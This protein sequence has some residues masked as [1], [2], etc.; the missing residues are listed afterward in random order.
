MPNPPSLPESR[1]VRAVLVV[2]TLSKLAGLEFDRDR[3]RSMLEIVGGDGRAD[4]T[5]LEGQD[6]NARGVLNYLRGLGDA[7]SDTVLVY[8]SGHGATDPGRG[9]ALTFTEGPP[10]LRSTLRAELARLRPR[11][12]VLISDCCSNVVKLPPA[13]GAPGAPDPTKT[14]RSLF[15]RTY[16]VVDINASTFD[17]R[18]GLEESAWGLADGGIFTKA[19]DETV[20]M[21]PFDELDRNRD[22][23]VTWGEC[24]PLVRNK[25]AGFYAD[26]RQQVLADPGRYPPR[27]VESLKRQSS[28]TPQAFSLDSGQGSGGG[29]GGRRELGILFTPVT[30]FDAT[31]GANVIG[32]R[33]DT[34]RAGLPAARVGL[35]AGDI[36]TLVNGRRFGSS[37]EFLQLLAQ[38]PGTSVLRIRNV[39]DGRFLDT[40]ITFGD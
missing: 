33:I 30:V 24:L 32:A 39:R 25:T 31:A 9:H 38:A 14:L 7:S 26:Y 3:M 19:L 18:T 13:V 4:V 40:Q 23:L 34:V 17:P 12:T 6:A 16:G 28:Q 27:T 10:L 21:T 5:I 8:Y 37:A 2:D 20:L 29:G 35:E 1:R 22:G 15:L 11:L 36:I